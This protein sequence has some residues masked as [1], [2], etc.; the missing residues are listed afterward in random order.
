MKISGDKGFQAFVMGI[1]L[2]ILLSATLAISVLSLQTFQETL[3]PAMERKAEVV[4][5]SLS[6]LT[7]KMLDYGVPLDRLRDI[8]EIFR[9]VTANNPD[10]GFISI[11]DDSGEVLYRHFAESASAPESLKE[12]FYLSRVPV[13]HQGGVV[14]EVVI[15]ADRG[16]MS[17]KLD[18]I[19]VDILTVLVV[20]GLMTF[21]LL[22]FLTTF[23]LASPLNT[24][25]DVLRSVRAGDFYRVAPLTGAHE[26]NRL[27]SLVNRLVRR[28]NGRLQQLGEET[29]EA[30]AEKY[31]FGTRDPKPVR[32]ARISYI[33]PP[34][35]LLIF[36]ESMSLS[37]FPIFVD[38]LYTPMA[39]VS[40][41]LVI[42]LPI[43]IFMLVWAV[44]LPFAGQWSDRRGR[45]TAFMLGAVVTSLGLVLT[46]LSQD[47]WQLLLFRSLTAVGYGMVF[48][49]AQGYISDNTTP[50]NRTKGMALFL[51]GFFAGSLCGAAIGGMLADRI[52]YR[53]TFLVSAVLG[54]AAALF[55]YRFLVDRREEEEGTVR[56]KLRVKDFQTLLTNKYF[57]II[58]FLSAIPAKTALTGILY[59]TGP[60]YLEE[61]GATQSAT[62]RILMAYGLA[63]IFLSPLSAWVVD[64]V[65]RKPPFIIAGGLLG[66]TSLLMTLLIPGV[67]GMLS[68]VVL[69]GVAHAIG[70]SPQLSLITELAPGAREGLS[71]GKTIGIF[72]LT[73]RIGNITG[74]LLAGGL[75][76]AFGFR[77]V[78]MGFGGL[79]LGSALLFSLLYLLF[80]IQDRRRMEVHAV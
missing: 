57:L 35:F 54:I 34:L 42:G 44:S 18:A 4:G 63:I 69:L 6:G 47:L 46:S 8:E 58:T 23:T 29:Q 45:R 30:M 77:G 60:L 40:K 20:S 36:A 38:Q 19:R 68:A 21:E 16:Y 26:V 74:P 39:G 9:S 32:T 66:G 55:V 79:I 27:A 41:S 59:Y 75:S 50:E 52:G 15:G 76:A 70:V 3:R 14:G 73:E 80:Q 49:S 56:P 11:R 25:R 12:R 17:Q 43:S 7:M 22:L 13:R 1:A 64:R 24:V 78:F 5:E 37:F 10:I 61:L 28:V 33:R 2:T 48:I 65:G 51:S 67:W 53:P 62:G 71:T 31:R 72:R